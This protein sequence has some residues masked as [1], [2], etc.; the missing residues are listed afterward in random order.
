MALLAAETEAVVARKVSGHT[1]YGIDR[2]SVLV[3]D[4]VDEESLDLDVA[5]D[6]V[7]TPNAVRCAM[8]GHLHVAPPDLLDEW[9]G[10][11]CLRYRCGGSFERAVPRPVNYYRDLYRD[12]RV[13][14]VVTGEHT[15]LLK[16]AP[17]RE[18][19]EAAFKAGTAP[20]APNVLTATPTLEMGIDIGDLSSVM[21]TSVPRTPAS[22]IQR[23][24]RSGRSS[25]NSL[26]TTFVP[27]DTHGLY[28][29]ADPEAMLAG[30]VRPPNCYLDALR[31]PATS[32]HRLPGGPHRRRRHRRAVVAAAHQQA[33]EEGPRHRAGFCGP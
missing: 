28:Y 22:Y 7:L 10:T 27:T 26:V 29:L 17:P 19:L 8:C 23:V 21:L 25:G 12:G 14:R 15:G 9:V 24:G 3:S 5:S 18:D 30:D 6:V 33:D 16:R 32:V 31:D 11:P 13:T 1:V 20:D 4:V 2:R